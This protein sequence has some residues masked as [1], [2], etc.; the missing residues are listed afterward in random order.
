EGV[1]ALFTSGHRR[2]AVAII[3]H[4]AL[5]PLT[6]IGALVAFSDAVVGR[7]L[8]LALGANL[9]SWLAAAA[10]VVAGLLV[11]WLILRIRRPM[12]HLIGNRPYEQRRVQNT[13]YNMVQ[14]LARLW[15]VP[16]LFFVATP[17]AAILNTGTQTT[18]ALLKA[19]VCAILLVLTLMV[20]SVFRRNRE[21]I[22]QNQRRNE[23]RPRLLRF[24]YSLAYYL[25]WVLFVE[26]SLRI[27]GLSLLTL[28]EKSRFAALVSRVLLELGITILLAWLAW[29]LIDT[30]ILRALNPRHAHGQRLANIRAQT[31]TPM[32]RNVA[33]FT[34][35][36][37]A[38]IAA[39]SNLGVNITP[40]LAGAGVIGLAIGFGA[41]TLVQDLITG[42]FILIEE[43]LAVGDF[44]EIRGHMGTVEGLNLR[45]V[46]LRDLDGIVHIITFSHIDSIHNMS[47]EFGTALMKI[48][49]PHD[50]PID[51]AIKLMKETA[52]QLRKDPF[53]RFRIWSPLEMQGIH[54]F[55][56]GCPILRMRFRTAPEYQW[57][58]A[59]AFN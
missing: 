37:I 35:L 3:H 32:L 38:G 41:Q 40:L 39:L 25:I 30:A 21:N 23:Y 36:L 8:S 22:P 26:L 4:N 1:T 55:E 29:V 6:I 50:L 16:A 13:A 49:L 17:L 24:G 10:S 34:I 20:G 2:T 33:F 53:I 52:E 11:V 7:R 15:Y 12:M 56:D 42:I 58:V 47:R 45:T 59:R 18:G 14:L 43:S 44:V 31:M 27:W 5:R 46:R 57:D 48:R 28:G 9:A 51:D 19:I 54:S